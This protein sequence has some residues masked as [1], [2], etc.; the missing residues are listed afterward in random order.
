MCGPGEQRHAKRGMN[1][2]KLQEL[3]VVYSFRASEE[4]IIRDAITSLETEIGGERE[5]HEGQ[6]GAVDNLSF[7]E[8]V[9]WITASL[10]VQI[11]AKKYLEGLLNADGIKKLGEDHR[12][13]LTEWTRSIAI[14]LAGI[15]AALSKL[16]DH[17]LPTLNYRGH[18]KALTLLIP[19]PAGQCYVT[20]NHARMSTRTLA[21]LPRGIMRLLEFM[22]Q[23]SL[24][25]DCRLFQ[26]YF[27]EVTHE[28]RYLLAPT[29]AGMGNWIDRYMDLDT[30]ETIMVPTPDEFKAKFNPAPEDALKFIVCPF[31]ND[32]GFEI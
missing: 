32:P 22:S 30:G 12:A 17:G 28:W 27:D 31:R 23:G 5:L 4:A 9:A 15:V 16:L 3:N 26:L 1:M 13:K 7:L 24:P 25:Q 6:K 14:D 11:V 18:A 20:L 19:I 8:I 10:P 2:Q 21:N 29:T